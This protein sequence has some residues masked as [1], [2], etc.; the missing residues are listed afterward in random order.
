[1]IF[2]GNEK[3]KKVLLFV[4]VSFFI[5]AIF[6]AWLKTEPIKNAG[7]QTDDQFW[8]ELASQS[9]DTFQAISNDFEIT[10]AELDNV[11]NDLEIAANQQALLEA[12]QEYLDEKASTTEEEKKSIK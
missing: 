10:K 12:A 9:G 3:N 5:V 11:K 4:L 6:W 1:M 8:A 7:T 2:L